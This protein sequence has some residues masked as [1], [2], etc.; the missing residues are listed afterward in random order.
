M[1]SSHCGPV[2]S[3]EF[4]FVAGCRRDRT[5]A[6]H[7]GPQPP[8]HSSGWPRPVLAR[9]SFPPHEPPHNPLSDQLVSIYN[10]TDY[11]VNPFSVLSFKLRNKCGKKK[12]NKTEYVSDIVESG[13]H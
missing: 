1:C 8:A 4:L 5:R 7:P 3:E 2:S 13:L 9:M 6:L 12:V 10:V 11:R